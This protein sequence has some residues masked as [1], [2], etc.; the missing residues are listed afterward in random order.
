MYFGDDQKA[1]EDKATFNALLDTLEEEIMTN[2][3]TQEHEPLYQK[4]Y[5]LRTTPVRGTVIVPKQAAIEAVEKTIGTLRF[6]RMI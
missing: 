6:C 2:R 3:R 5:E 4:Y 1:V